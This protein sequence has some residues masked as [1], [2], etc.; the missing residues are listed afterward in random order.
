M[1]DEGLTFVI[2]SSKYYVVHQMLTFFWLS[3]VCMYFKV[4]YVSR[5]R[6]DILKGVWVSKICFHMFICL[7]M[8]VIFLT[9]E[10]YWA[11]KL[12]F[13]IGEISWN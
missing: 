12:K 9:G 2:I 1:C 10:F 4:Q 6:A 7:K 5:Q 11:K 8:S 13:L 3:E